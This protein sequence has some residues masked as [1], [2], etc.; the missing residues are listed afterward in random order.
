MHK[1]N[2]KLSLYVPNCNC[3]TGIRLVLLKGDLHE[4]KYFK[5]ITRRKAYIVICYSSYFIAIVCILRSKYHCRIFPCWYTNQTWHESIHRYCRWHTCIPCITKV[6]LFL[7]FWHFYVYNRIFCFATVHFL[8]FIAW[9]LLGGN[10]PNRILIQIP[11]VHTGNA[12]SFYNGTHGNRKCPQTGT[13]DY[14]QPKQELKHFTLAQHLY[15]D[16]CS[17]WQCL[18]SIISV[19]RIRQKRAEAC[20]TFLF[21]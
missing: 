21:L 1:G 13:K 5:A 14:N 7:I 4:H 9:P 16:S 2:L 17:V 12:S 18:P 19:Q 3:G 6:L 8:V 10:K 11:P 15:I 20:G